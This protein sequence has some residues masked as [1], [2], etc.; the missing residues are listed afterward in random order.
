MYIHTQYE[1][2]QPSV[3]LLLHKLKT[4]TFGNVNRALK[5]RKV[6]DI[7]LCL[8]HDKCKEMCFLPTINMISVH[9]AKL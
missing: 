3:L 5:V 1:L 6:L 7:H 4:L 9:H 8:A 2:N